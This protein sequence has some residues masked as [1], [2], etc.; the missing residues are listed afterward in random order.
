MSGQHVSGTEECRDCHYEAPRVWLSFII[1][2]DETRTSK[3]GDLEMKF[4]YKPGILKG[5][6]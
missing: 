6:T 1:W 2:G 3:G 5:L 4:P